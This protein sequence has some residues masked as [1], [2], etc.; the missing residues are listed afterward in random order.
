M[1]INSRSPRALR[2][3]K[4][5]IHQ[6]KRSG[7]NRHHR[8]APDGKQTPSDD[9]THQLSFQLSNHGSTAF[10]TLMFLNGRQDDDYQEKRKQQQRDVQ[11]TCSSVVQ[12]SDWP[13]CSTTLD[14]TNPL[15]QR[16]ADDKV[17]EEG[18]SLKGSVGS[19]TFS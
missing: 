3:I 17:Q 15:Q 16:V 10:I 2:S 7:E 6:T 19:C 1:N 18:S 13:R 12:T 8:R 5:C 4:V 11:G 14:P 9:A